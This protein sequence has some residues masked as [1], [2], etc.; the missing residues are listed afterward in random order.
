MKTDRGSVD[1]RQE[2]SACRWHK[3]KLG[4]EVTVS[5]GALRGS[6]SPE[7]EWTKHPSDPYKASRALVGDVGHN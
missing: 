1:Q 4:V 2:S 6:C 3:R 7:S 5:Q